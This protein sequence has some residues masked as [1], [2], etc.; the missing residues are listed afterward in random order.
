MKKTIT[1][2]QTHFVE[3]CSKMLRRTAE[4]ASNEGPESA[5]SSLSNRL[6]KHFVACSADV[7]MAAGT[8][9]DASAAV[10]SWN[11]ANLVIPATWEGGVISIVLLKS[12]TEPQTQFPTPN[13]QT[14]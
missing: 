5:G 3:L 14:I 9:G 8:T 2:I 4:M 12:R 13:T 7:A 6:A 11:N 1:N 10:V